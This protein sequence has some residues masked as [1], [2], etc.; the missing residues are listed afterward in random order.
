MFKKKEINK[1]DII[2]GA[3]MRELRIALGMSQSKLADAVGI[4]FQQIQKYERGTN[5]M[6]S[7]RLF[8]ICQALGITVSKLFED[9]E[10]EAGK[11]VLIKKE[12]PTRRDLEIAKNLTLLNRGNKGVVNEVMK[13]LIDSQPIGKSH[14]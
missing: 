7:S 12:R 9:I 3:R 8:Q 14:D 11:P 5:R 4:T 2:I 6:G 10:K 1:I 13:I